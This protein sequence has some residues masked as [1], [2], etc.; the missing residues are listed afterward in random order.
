MPRVNQSLLHPILS[1]T[2]HASYKLQNKQ[3]GLRDGANKDAFKQDNPVL[4][5]AL[6]KS[7]FH[8]AIQV[9]KGARSIVRASNGSAWY[10]LKEV[11]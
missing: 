2:A 5:K 6:D 4:F 9:R 3:A 7:R 8:K 1:L 11:F 10:G